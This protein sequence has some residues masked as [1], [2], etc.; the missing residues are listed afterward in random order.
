M[1][2]EKVAKVEVAVEVEEDHKEEE[3]VHKHK[4]EEDDELNSSE[5]VQHELE[6]EQGSEV[7]READPTWP[8]RGEIRAT[9]PLFPILTSRRPLCFLD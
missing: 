2:A 7:D 9:R 4:E 5:K 3:E 8:T 6:R 1:E